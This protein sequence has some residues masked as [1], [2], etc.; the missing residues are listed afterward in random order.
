MLSICNRLNKP[1]EHHS[2]LSDDE[3]YVAWHLQNKQL[4]IN[5]PDSALLK[6]TSDLWTFKTKLET[7]KTY[8]DYFE[9]KLPN[10]CIDR[11]S[12][13]ATVKAISHP[14][15]NYLHRIPTETK[16]AKNSTNDLSDQCI[17]YPI[18][19]LHYG[20]VNQADLK[21]FHKLPSILVRLTQLYWIEQLRIVFASEIKSYTVGEP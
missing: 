18:E 14:R 17:H 6:R 19:L 8:A 15:I 3:V 11:D 9:Y 7:I 21:L 2:Q 12:L 13:M 4:Y 10:V 20:P 16:A 5:M 1:V